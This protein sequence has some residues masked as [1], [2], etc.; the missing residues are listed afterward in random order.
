MNRNE[1]LE[2]KRG[3]MV[4]NKLLPPIPDNMFEI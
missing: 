4:S 3:S 2:K 1:G